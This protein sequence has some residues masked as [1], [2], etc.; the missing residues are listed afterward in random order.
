MYSNLSF[1]RL[2]WEKPRINL[3]LNGKISLK[4]DSQFEFA[5]RIPSLVLKTISVSRVKRRP[6]PFVEIDIE[7]LKSQ[8]SGDN[9]DGAGIISHLLLL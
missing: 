2:S 5:F 3:Q 4:L 9:I 7:I 1:V 8:I 6:R